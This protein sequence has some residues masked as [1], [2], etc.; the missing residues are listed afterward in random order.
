MSIDRRRFLQ[1]AGLG[2]ALAA[3]GTL[4]LAQATPAV[5]EDR[6]V[7]PTPIAVPFLGA[8]Q[9]GVYRPETLQPAACFAAFR[10]LSSNAAELQA[11]LHTLT[12]RIQS[13][14]EGSLVPAARQR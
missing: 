12:D 13:L 14:S 3:A 11:L 8:N 2:S 1:G 6:S 7:D 5:A 9:A 10:V 4:G